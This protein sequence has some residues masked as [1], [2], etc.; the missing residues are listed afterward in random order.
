LD[1]SEH[2]TQP[3]FNKVRLG[4]SPISPSS[5]LPKHHRG[6]MSLIETLGAK[7]ESKQFGLGFADLDDAK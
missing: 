4:T 5:R 2:S 7:V 6:G 3:H 1:L